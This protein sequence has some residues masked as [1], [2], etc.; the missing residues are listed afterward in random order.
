MKSIY[1]HKQT[2]DLFAIETDPQGSIVSASGPLLFDNLDPRAM[3][4]DDYWNAE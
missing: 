3:D 2:G 1:R 4:Y